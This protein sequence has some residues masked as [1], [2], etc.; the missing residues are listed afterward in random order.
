ML[1]LS[2]DLEAREMRERIQP[3]TPR[4]LW[5]IVMVIS[6]VVGAQSTKAENIACWGDN[7][8]EDISCTKLTPAFVLIMRGAPRSE[9]LKSMNAVGRK[10]EN[11]TLHFISNAD[12]GLSGWTGYI[13]FTFE[14]DRVAIIYADIDGPEGVMQNMEF[15]WN[16][17]LGGCSDFPGSTKRCR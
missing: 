8:R 6:V 17:R 10:F 15:I 7:E 9:V 2:L 13:N 12:H 1:A 3:S 11:D 14:N 5:I 4:V 16:V